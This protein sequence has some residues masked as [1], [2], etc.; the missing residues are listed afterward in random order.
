MIP[1]EELKA[2]RKRCEKATEGPWEAVDAHESMPGFQIPF[3]PKSLV[4]KNLSHHAPNNVVFIVHARDDLPRCLDEI[5]ALQKLL[6][7]AEKMA[8]FYAKSKWN[9]DYPGG[10][11]EWKKSKNGEEDCY[12]DTGQRARF[13]ISDLKKSRG[14]GA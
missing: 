5:E 7:S 14:E 10:I 3:M 9:D 2:M 1:P 6:K 13:F 8:E 12:L 11:T 4:D